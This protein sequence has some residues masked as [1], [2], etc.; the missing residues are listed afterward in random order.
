MQ[1][2]TL[3][4]QYLLYMN[5]DIGLAI[6]IQTDNLSILDSSSNMRS[7]NRIFHKHTITSEDI[8]FAK[9]HFNNRAFAWYVKTSDLDSINLLKQNNLKYQCS[10]PAMSINLNI[11]QNY[12]YDQKN[13]TI[14]EISYDDPR[15]DSEWLVCIIQAIQTPTFSVAA[16]AFTKL[17]H[18]FATQG[19]NSIRFYLGLY[20][21][22]VV[23]AAM[24]IYH[25]DV[26]S[27]HWVGTLPE[28][29]GKGIGTAICYKIIK[30][31]QNAGYQ[32]AILLATEMGE[33]LYKKLGFDE[34]ALYQVYIN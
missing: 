33:P 6:D 8:A 21:N 28:F 29:R 24:A 20:Q 26:I 34:Y 32:E 31:A 30:D 4:L 7:G 5:P 9:K 12:E 15:V 16:D 2:S 23:T 18:R 11:I 27:L 14:E 3:W 1:L 13:I 19:K 10:L 22:K 25:Q 17:I